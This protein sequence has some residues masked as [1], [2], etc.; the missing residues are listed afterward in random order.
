MD[1][2]ASAFTGNSSFSLVE[3]VKAQYPYAPND[4]MAFEIL[5]DDGYSREYQNG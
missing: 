4:A 2:M 1:Q 5:E 3:M